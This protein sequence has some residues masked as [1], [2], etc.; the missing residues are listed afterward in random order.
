MVYVGF[1]F[2]QAQGGSIVPNFMQ[3]APKAI[4]LRNE[5]YILRKTVFNFLNDT[6]SL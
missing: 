4:S 6:F 5:T 1:W 3:L 2:K